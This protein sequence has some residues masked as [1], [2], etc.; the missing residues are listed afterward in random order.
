M[1]AGEGRSFTGGRFALDVGGHNVGFIKKFSG[2]NLEGTVAEN[3]TGPDNRVYKHI[4]TIKPTEAS[5]DMGIGMGKGMYEWIKE[6]F[7]KQFK[8]RSGSF[9]NADFDY[10]A[11]SAVTFHD[12]LIT[13]VTVPK[14]DG[15]SKDAAY[16]TIKFDAERVEYA[17]AGGESI[18]ST[19]GV[20]QKT[21]LCCNFKLE[22]DGLETGRVASVESFTWKCSVVRDQIG[23][24]RWSTLHP[25]KVSTPEIKFSV[26]YDDHGKWA[27]EVEKFIVGGEAENQHERGGRLIFLSPDMKREL[28]SITFENLGFTKFE[29]A[30]S[31]ANGESI[32]R[33]NVSMYCEKM[34][35]E[36]KEV[37]A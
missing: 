9:T 28:G 5:V 19:F 23:S 7:D 6:S 1:A 31:V 18:K 30:E 15:G 4:T 22:I 14:M 35:F 8:P 3:D 10:K 36:L 12:A 25:A 2:L 20:K 24:N 11:R 27:P 26:S 34:G 37:D 29:S 16:F 33:F 13:S 32:M 17:K 21:W